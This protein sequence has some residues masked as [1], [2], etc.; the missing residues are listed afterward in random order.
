MSV[1]YLAKPKEMSSHDIITRTTDPWMN[2][3]A[4]QRQIAQWRH[5]LIAP[6]IALVEQGSSINHAAQLLSK[7]IETGALDTLQKSL[8]S[9]L[10]ENL[11]MPTVKRWLAAFRND[12]KA[13]LLPKHCGRV[14][15]DYG[16]EARATALFNLPSKPGYS[17]VA[18]RLQKEGYETATESRVKRYLKSLPATLG[19]QS[20]HRVGKHLHKLQRQIW[21]PRDRLSVDVGEIYAGDGHTCDCYVAHPNTGRLYR[22]EL[23]AFI[24]VRS[25]YIVGWY[26]SEAESSLSTLFALSSAMVRYN[27]VPAA[28]YLDRGAGYR[29]KLM[30]DESTGFYKRFDMTVIGAIPGNPHGKGWIE[31]WFRTVRDHHDKFFFDGQV[32]CG[33]DMAPEINRRLSSDLDRGKRKIPQ[34]EE[35]VSS[36]GRFI[37]EYNHTPMPALAG[38]SP[39]E[40]W[41]NLENVAVELPADAVIR[42][43][44]IRTVQKRHIIELHKRMYWHDALALYEQGTRLAVE[45]DLHD[46]KHVWL[47]EENGRFVCVANL[48]K[49]IGV[50]PSS[51]LEEQRALRLA[52]QRKRLERKMSEQIARSGQIIDADAI[53][54]A[55]TLLPED[56]EQHD[57]TLVI[58]LVNNRPARENSLLKLDLNL[59]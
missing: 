9:R 15:K 48:V 4:T 10:K 21:K 2:A 29:S 37:E 47:F 30:N 8:V 13:G 11:S 40:V 42:P 44:E 7:R 20:P 49:T 36:L 19:K 6:A 55:V 46:D 53:A 45:Y 22:P 26:L 16:W 18:L 38:L 28:L 3:S 25:A 43:R 57:E 58:D 1:S 17:A 56:M 12:G 32:Y 54:D 23:T 52:G 14:R 31:R 24:D 51:R 50:I 5:E 59:D 39:A 35:Y 41:T 27:H 34:L 33:D